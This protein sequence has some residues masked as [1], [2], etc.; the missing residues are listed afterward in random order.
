MTKALSPG[1][2]Q[3]LLALW[4]LGRRAT[5]EEVVQE[6]G[7]EPGEEDRE[8]EE[9][10][11]ENRAHNRTFVV[12]ASSHDV[13]ALRRRAPPLLASGPAQESYT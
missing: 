6:L 3:I 13:G 12:P 7:Q 4:R 10:P 1:E 11:D 2:W 8:G 5:V 9:A